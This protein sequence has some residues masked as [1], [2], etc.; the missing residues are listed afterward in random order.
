MLEQEVQKTNATT[1]LAD[2]DEV[3]VISS[4]DE[5]ISEY[6]DNDVK[7]GEDDR[8]PVAPPEMKRQVT[9]E[10]VQLEKQFG[11]VL[12]N[13]KQ[14]EIL[15][16]SVYI[17]N[18]KND[19]YGFRIRLTNQKLKDGECVWEC[20]RSVLELNRL[21]QKL[22]KDKS[23][24][25][26]GYSVPPL[27]GKKLKV[28]NE[29]MDSDFDMVVMFARK[30][31]TNLVFLKHSMVL[32]TFE[33]PAVVRTKIDS[34]ARIHQMPLLS[35]YMNK[36]GW[37]VKNW[38]KRWFVLYPDFTLRYYE[39]KSKENDGGTGFRGL[40]DIQDVDKIDHHK[41]GEGKN[42]SFRLYLSLKSDWEKT[43]RPRV[44]KF[45]TDEVDI[46][47]R[48]IKALTMLRDGELAKFIPEFTL[49]DMPTVEELAGLS[50]RELRGSFMHKRVS[51]ISQIQIKKE[52]ESNVKLLS[53]LSE[54]RE[55]RDTFEENQK[56]EQEQYE[57]EQRKLEDELSDLKVKL[58]AV[59][60]SHEREQEILM[61]LQQELGEKEKKLEENLQDAK[62]QVEKE[63][64]RFNLKTAVFNR[65]VGQP[66][67]RK[68][69]R[70]LVEN[71]APTAYAG[72]LLMLTGESEK[73][74]RD[75]WY[76]L[77][78]NVPFMEWADLSVGFD[79]HSATR[80]QIAE[81]LPGKSEYRGRAFVVR[82]SKKDKE[83][84]FITQ[85]VS[86]CQKW[87]RTIKN[88][89]GL[90][91]DSEYDFSDRED[92]KLDIEVPSYSGIDEYK[93]DLLVKPNSK[94]IEEEKG[95]VTLST[96]SKEIILEELRQHGIDGETEV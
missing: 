70:T 38:K 86:E 87:I 32:N 8:V 76:I 43:Q 16:F 72:R 67:L 63:R 11:K 18:T 34:M 89:L 29:V 65:Q 13:M 37:N 12:Y 83:I 22:Q 27:P 2:V 25:G 69:T 64:V 79:P 53:K 90:W 57:R 42:Q 21:A 78:S 41:K 30:M 61:T 15:K 35:A 68:R 10:D 36:Q 56:K 94:I 85:K 50:K 96:V 59:M 51:R 39:S 3:A 75:V 1:E 66:T 52:R 73:R 91:S 60:K 5:D 46:R 23:I 84:T 81:V 24:R 71:S 31:F 92:V 7:M 45:D 48:W 58:D 80:M 33:V 62:K 95:E 77:I 88:G 26:I 93:V 44:Y 4:S 40:V 9:D 82:S 74:K 14:E 55:A 17:A 20:V 28:K 19:K 54:M 47:G 6:G 49:Q